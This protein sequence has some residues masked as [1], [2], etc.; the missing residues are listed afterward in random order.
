MRFA[1]FRATVAGLAAEVCSK[2][3]HI[4]N[5]NSASNNFDASF[6]LKPARAVSA[7]V[8]PQRT[9]RHVLARLLVRIRALT[10]RLQPLRTER[11]HGL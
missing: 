6:M 2:Q 4:L 10:K 3:K 7:Y 11:G 5:Y 9:E 1:L 8:P